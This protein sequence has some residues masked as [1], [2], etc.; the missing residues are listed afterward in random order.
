VDARDG[1]RIMMR[2]RRAIALVLGL[3]L[4]STSSIARSHPLDNWENLR[5]LA[6]GRSIEV[7]R[8][9]HTTVKGAF[10]GVDNE[11]LHL[12]KSGQEIT[13]ARPD[14]ALVRTRSAHAW[15]ATWI[16]IG[17]GA[18]VGLAVGFGLG[19]NLNTASGGDFA[20]LKPVIAGGMAGVGALIGA[21]VGSVIGHRHDT[22]YRAR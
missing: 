9:D 6:P 12:Q 8:T 3:V 5:A 21:V 11:A 14:V 16:G 7:F 17:I 4:L 19:E 22:V 1:Y 15:R 13:I 20:N 10:A 2:T 18:G